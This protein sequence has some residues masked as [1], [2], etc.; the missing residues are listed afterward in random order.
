MSRRIVL[1]LSNL[2]FAALYSVLPALAQ[3]SPLYV[4]RDARFAVIFPEQ[5]MMREIAYTTRAGDSVPARQFFIE[6]GTSRYIVTVVQFPGG[7]AEDRRAVEHAAENLRRRGEVRFQAYADYDPGIP[8]RQLNI[9][10]PGGRQLRAS[11]YMYDRRLYITE[12]NAEPGD[13]AAIQ[14]EQS[15]MLLDEDGG[16][17]DREGLEL[18]LA[19]IGSL[20]GRLL[21]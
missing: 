14:F 13:V 8:G 10:E 12:A 17:V 18:V 19:F 20:F 3:E 21:P 2:L 16:D 11:V 5:P 6:E 9:F 15:I 4:N 1:F 7:R